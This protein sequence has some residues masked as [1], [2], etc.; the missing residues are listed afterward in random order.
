MNIAL[1]VNILDQVGGAEISTR[2]LAEHFAHCG[3]QVT[4]VTTKPLRLSCNQTLID[5]AKG[6]RFIRLPV[7]QRSP[8]IFRQM[9]TLQAL[10]AFPLLLR[11]TQI[12]H[13]RGLTPEALS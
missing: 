2:R 1:F 7:W 8:S 9:L 12:I 11:D 6:V 4:I 10:W 5:Y 3:H 13:L